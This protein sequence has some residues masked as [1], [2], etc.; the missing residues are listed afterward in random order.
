MEP[1]EISHSKNER[2]ES[3]PASTILTLDVAITEI[4]IIPI[5]ITGTIILSI[6]LEGPILSSGSPSGVVLHCPKSVV[7]PKG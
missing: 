4:I 1:S 7:A 3:L 5:I 6:D 2:F